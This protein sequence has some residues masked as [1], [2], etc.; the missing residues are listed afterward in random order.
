MRR[1]AIAFLLFA[2]AGPAS[3]EPALSDHFYGGK[4]ADAEEALAKRLAD[5]PDDDTRFALGAARFL[6]AVEKLGAGLHGY[7]LRTDSLSFLAPPLRKLFAPNPK[8]RKISYADLR[9]LVRGFLDDLA[10]AEKTLAEVKGEKVA[11][12]LEVGRIKLDLLGQGRPVSAAELLAAAGMAAE[13]KAAQKLAIRFDRGDVSWLRGYIH[14][15]SAWGELYLALDG[16]ALFET[17]AHRVFARV[18]T[19]NDFLLDEEDGSVDIEGVARVRPWLIIDAVAFLHQATDLRV[20]DPAGVRKALA[21]LQSTV[22]HG[23][24]MWEHI[25]A[26]TD[27]EEEWIPNP[28]QRSVVP[29]KVTREMI[30]EWRSTLGEVEQ[31]LAGKKLVPFWRGKKGGRGVDLHKAFTDP[32]ERLDLVGWIQGPAARPYLKEGTIT[33]LADPKKVE[34]LDRT[35]GGVAFFGFAL[36]FN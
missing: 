18:D 26:E 9:K 27:D 33:A 1:S 35:F 29:V 36:W 31:V 13:G 7:G 3:S 6:R 30:D 10:E 19:P 15:L 12:R 8:P 28:K 32:P 11:L 5:K 24:E 34:R 16:Q 20:K 2:A 4:L 22:K 17:T 21:H 14:F 25:L 23:Q